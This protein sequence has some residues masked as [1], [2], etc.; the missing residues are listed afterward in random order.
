MGANGL[1][2]DINQVCRGAV[3]LLAL[4]DY[5]AELLKDDNLFALL[6]P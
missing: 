2:F 6:A 1:G 3:T 5:P 4:R